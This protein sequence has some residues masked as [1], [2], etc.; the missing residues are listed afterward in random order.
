MPNGINSLRYDVTVTKITL[1]L[2]NDFTDGKLLSL[3]PYSDIFA[4]K[5]ED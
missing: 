2:L 5:Y 3:K 1:D 4:Y